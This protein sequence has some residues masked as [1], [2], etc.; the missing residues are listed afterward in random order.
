MCLVTQSC[1]ALCNPMDCSPACSSEHRDSPGKNTGVGCHA[2]LQGIFPTQGSNWE[3]NKPNLRAVWHSVQQSSNQTN[4]NINKIINKLFTEYIF[5]VISHF[6][7][8]AVLCA[9]SPYNP[10]I[11]CHRFHTYSTN[12]KRRELKPS[13]K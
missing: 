5:I 8:L 4:V 12:T 3:P 1:P 9:P 11:S 10:D 6:P 13:E 7:C 2:L